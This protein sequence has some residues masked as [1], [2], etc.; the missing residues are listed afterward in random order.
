VVDSS[1]YR[2]LAALASGFVFF[3]APSEFRACG[4]QL[5]AVTAKPPRGGRRPPEAEKSSYAKVRETSSS[6]SSSWIFS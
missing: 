2:T 4:P 1:N 6:V 5:R 3:F